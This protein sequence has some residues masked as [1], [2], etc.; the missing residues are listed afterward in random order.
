MTWVVV[1]LPPARSP[2][3][4]YCENCFHAAVCSGSYMPAQREKVAHALSRRQQVVGDP[5][6]SCRQFTKHASGSQPDIFQRANGVSRQHSGSL[7]DPCC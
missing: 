3:R 7:R 1:D 6:R 5:E 2:K 4:P